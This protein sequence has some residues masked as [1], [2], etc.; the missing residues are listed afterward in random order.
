MP[1]QL[2]SQVVGKLNLHKQGLLLHPGQ[3]L[4]NFVMLVLVLVLM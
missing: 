2:L 3:I 1:C 4:L